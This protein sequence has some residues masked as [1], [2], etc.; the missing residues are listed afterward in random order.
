MND[1]VKKIEAEIAAAEP[2]ATPP[3]ENVEALAPENKNVVESEP[4]VQGEPEEASTGDSA[5][6]DGTDAPARTNKGVGKRINELTRERHEERRAREDAE[7]RLKEMQAELDKYRQSQQQPRQT[8]VASTDDDFG[9]TL[10]S[11]DFDPV[12]WQRELNEWNRKQIRKELENGKKEEAQKARY[13]SYQQ[14]ADA[15][16]DE[17]PDYAE[18]AEEL[19]VTDAMRA[20]IMQTENEPVIVYHLANHP[21]EVSAIVGLDPLGQ[22]FAIAK[23]E[24]RLTQAQ[25]SAVPPPPSGITPPPPPPTVTARS[26]AKVPVGNK[27][28]DDFIEDLRSRNRR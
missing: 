1:A 19:K 25:S 11:C 18:K 20:A 28:V 22:A 27:S 23:L 2:K 17:H 15:F 24:S 12:R 21:E 26:P 4:A 10:E 14:R 6:P 13:Q 3:S 7:N 5:N 8:Q 16:A 9:P